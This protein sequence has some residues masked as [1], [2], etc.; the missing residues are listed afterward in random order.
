MYNTDIVGVILCLVTRVAATG[1]SGGWC[2]W[3]N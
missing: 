1:R 3:Y 2:L